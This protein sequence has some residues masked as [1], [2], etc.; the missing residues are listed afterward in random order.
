MLTAI[1]STEK[2]PLSVSSLNFLIT[3]NLHGMRE[4]E[5]QSVKLQE[6]IVLMKHFNFTEK[7]KV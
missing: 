3:L 2:Y 6:S 1:P 5:P 7:K 4:R